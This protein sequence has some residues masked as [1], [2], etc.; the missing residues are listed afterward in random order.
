M[1]DDD[2]IRE[3]GRTVIRQR[4]ARKGFG[5]FWNRVAIAFVLCPARKALRGS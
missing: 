5:S 4:P 1:A 2:V 3:N